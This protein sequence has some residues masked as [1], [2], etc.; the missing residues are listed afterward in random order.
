M[1]RIITVAP[2]ELRQALALSPQERIRQANAALRLY[3]ALHRPYAK[4]WIMAG[5]S[6]ARGAARLPG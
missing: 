3:L 4:P 6:P 1:E 2:E 5:E